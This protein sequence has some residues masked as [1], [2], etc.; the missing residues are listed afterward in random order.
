MIIPS[1]VC[2]YY[3]L[4]FTIPINNNNNTRYY[5]LTTYHN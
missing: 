4:L 1:V 3:L 2:E 5:G